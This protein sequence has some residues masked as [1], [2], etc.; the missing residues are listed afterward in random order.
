[1][2]GLKLKR[3]RLTNQDGTSYSSENTLSFLPPPLSA[4]P[5]L[6]VFSFLTDIIEVLSL[7]LSFSCHLIG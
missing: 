4:L 2:V 3:A 5:S 6:S 7:I 1:M